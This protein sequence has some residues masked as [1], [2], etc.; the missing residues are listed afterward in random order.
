MWEGVMP[1]PLRQIWRLV[2]KNRSEK[3]EYEKEEYEKEEYEK[4]GSEKDE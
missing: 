2:R 4:G 3:Y 1:M